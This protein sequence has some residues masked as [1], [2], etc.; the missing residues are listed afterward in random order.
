MVPII[1]LV[2][3]SL[4]SS[5]F[6]R[7]STVPTNHKCMSDTFCSS[8]PY[9]TRTSEAE[10]DAQLAFEG[11]ITQRKLWTDFGKQDDD[12]YASQSLHTRFNQGHPLLLL[13]CAM[14]VWHFFL[15]S[16]I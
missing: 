4:S 6:L 15:S 9:I 2:K 1:L 3:E 16:Y 8:Q 11:T 13:A 10:L 5:S 14:I 7:K 12:C